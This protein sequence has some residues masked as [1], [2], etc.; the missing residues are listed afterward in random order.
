[1]LEI[2]SYQL[3]EQEVISNL[4]SKTA[5]C[6]TALVSGSLIQLRGSIPENFWPI[7]VSI[8]GTSP[9]IQLLEFILGLS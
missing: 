6:C 1:M 8:G 5:T 3:Q 9:V 4:S 2:H 7:M